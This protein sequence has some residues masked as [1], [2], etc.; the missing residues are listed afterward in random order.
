[1]PALVTAMWIGPSSLRAE[2]IAS[3]TPDRSVT[4][5]SYPRASNPSSCS[6]ES[7]CL[8]MSPRRSRMATLSPRRAKRRLMAAPIPDA[9]PVTTATL[10]MDPALSLSSVVSVNRGE[11]QV[12]VAQPADDEGGVV[13]EAAL[14]F[15]SMVGFGERD[16]AGAVQ[17]AFQCDA[18]LGAGQR[19]ARAGVGAA[20]EGDVFAH[21]VAPE[22]TLG[23]PL[24][25]AVVTVGGPRVDHHRGSGRDVDPAQGG[26]DAGHPEIAHRGALQPQHFFDELGN[27]LAVGS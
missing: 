15:R 14:T 17:E 21:I 23:G 26:R 13:V 20:A 27:E 25:A 24:E 9:P 10:L 19:A 6:A 2:A 4:S 12:Q 7:C 3:C 22:Q 11:H 5:T 8:R 16:V 1:M 18:P